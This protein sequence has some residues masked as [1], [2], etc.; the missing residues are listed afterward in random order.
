MADENLSYEVGYGKPPRACRFQ[1]GASGNPKGRPKGR[2]NLSTIVLQESRQKV[3][4]NGPRGSRTV[5]KL[6]AVVMQLGNKSA[7]GDVRASRE[8]IA[9]VQRSEESVG[10]GAGPIPLS[11]LDQQVMENL[12]RRMSMLQSEGN[13]NQ[14]EEA[15]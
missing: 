5:T 13:N 1:K 10:S 8:F 11:E 4:V 7:Q 3:R 6:Q 12:R 14:P 9:L 15:R 2:K